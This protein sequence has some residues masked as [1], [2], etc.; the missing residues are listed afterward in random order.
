MEKM[1]TQS[2]SCPALSS[3]QELPALTT[4]T[5][6]VVLGAASASHGRQPRLGWQHW[7]ALAVPSLCQKLTSGLGKAF[8]SAHRAWKQ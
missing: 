8:P 1:D 4:N 6:R 3:G 7:R 2:S 5:G